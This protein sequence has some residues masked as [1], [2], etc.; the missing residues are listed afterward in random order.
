M[1]DN[2]L[3]WLND[4]ASRGLIG[5]KTITMQEYETTITTMRM[6]PYEI[7]LPEYPDTR[8]MTKQMYLRDGGVFLFKT[9]NDEYLRISGT[10]E[11]AV[12]AYNIGA[13]QDLV[14]TLY[15]FNKL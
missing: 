11:I 5:I 13:T 9:E 1:T 3:E 7:T 4:V 8:L 2:D 15:Q 10:L 6:K 12:R 14:R